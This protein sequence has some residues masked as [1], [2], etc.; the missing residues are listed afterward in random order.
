[1]D[2]N[3]YFTP[4]ASEEV[5]QSVQDE[6]KKRP[7]VEYVQYVSRDQALENF[8]YRYRNDPDVLEALFELEENPLGAIL[9]VKAKDSSQYEGIATYLETTY[10]TGAADSVISEVNFNENK[11][12]IERLTKFIDAG[13]KLGGIVTL[14][15]IAI[16]IIITFNTIRLA[17]YIS[18]D[19]IKVMRLVGASSSY[20]SGPFI[21]TGI[22]YGI[23]SSLLTLLALYPLTLWT[24]NMTA[25]F[26]SGINIAQ[27]YVSHFGQ[28]FLMIFFSAIFIGA[29]SSFIAVKKYLREARKR[30]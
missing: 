29:V 9:N 3:V 26:F 25:D 17:M 14:L 2:V 1:V 20:I 19:E 24:G 27:Y 8:K 28:F 4:N 22:L 11:E 6:L 16:S 13:Q 23:V 7:D 18:R 5:A 12:I 30:G 21:V 15:F 10:P